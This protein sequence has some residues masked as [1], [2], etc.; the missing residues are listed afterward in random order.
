MRRHATGLQQVASGARGVA[1]LAPA[2]QGGVWR[3]ENAPAIESDNACVAQQGLLLDG[4]RK[5]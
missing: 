5:S 3:K 2:R 4:Y 1:S